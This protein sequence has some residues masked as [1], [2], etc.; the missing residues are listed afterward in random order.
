MTGTSDDID[1]DY[2]DLESLSTEQREV[3]TA[4]AAFLWSAS[5]KPIDQGALSDDIWPESP[6][7]VDWSKLPKFRK[8]HTKRAAVK[9]ITGY[10]CENLIAG[11]HSIVVV[12]AVNGLL[13]AAFDDYALRPTAVDEKLYP[14]LRWLWQ[15]GVTTWCSCQGF[16]N[17]GYLTF[18][19]EENYS[20]AYWL[21]LP[22]FKGLP[23]FHMLEDTN[24]SV[25][26]MSWYWD[27]EIPPLDMLL[28]TLAITY[29][30]RNTN[31]RD[32]ASF[33]S[34]RRRQLLAYRRHRV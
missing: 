9:N 16:P 20:R 18:Y 14:V 32:F 26:G 8:E 34:D 3:W 19:G 6:P 33:Y 22:H 29:Y 2:S 24:K 12:P 15:Q 11:D 17:S 27:G 25:F 7:V 4:K 28:D 21:M 30:Q 5:V 31:A 10:D 13:A 23:G 1:W